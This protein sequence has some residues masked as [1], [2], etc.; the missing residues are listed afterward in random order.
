MTVRRENKPFYLG[1]VQETSI[2]LPELIT[3][4]RLVLL[5]EECARYL[6]PPAAQH[7]VDS[8]FVLTL[9]GFRACAE[10]FLS[11][12]ADELPIKLTRKGQSQ[13]ADLFVSGQYGVKFLLVNHPGFDE[14]TEVRLVA[15]SLSGYERVSRETDI[16]GVTPLA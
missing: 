9:A 3:G 8:S 12:S 7:L 13:V 11:V 5:A 15:Q 2:V 4:D 14:D 10:T 16:S 6:P 1:S